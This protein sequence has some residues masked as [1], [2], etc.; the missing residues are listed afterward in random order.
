MLR[1][2]GLCPCGRIPKVFAWNAAPRRICACI[3][4][5]AKGL[6]HPIN[7]NATGSVI[8]RV[9]D[10]VSY[11][12]AYSFRAKVASIKDCGFRASLTRHTN[13]SAR[14]ICDLSRQC[15]PNIINETRPQTIDF[16]R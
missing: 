1:A 12:L 6:D 4:V 13:I 7:R 3:V 11:N 5:S 14:V 2:F 10:F 15:G 16:F 9:A 8:Y